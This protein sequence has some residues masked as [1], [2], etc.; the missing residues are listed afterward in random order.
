MTNSRKAITS[1]TKRLYNQ[2]LKN[3]GRLPTGGETKKLAQKARRVAER[4]G[5]RKGGS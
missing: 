4:V 3:K 2:A 1:L 5:R